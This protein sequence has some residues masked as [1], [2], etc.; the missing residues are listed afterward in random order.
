MPDCRMRIQEVPGHLLASVG[1]P[2]GHERIM[3][4]LGTC[5]NGC[6]TNGLVAV[7]VIG[8]AEARRYSIPPSP[9]DGSTT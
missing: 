1:I 9:P 5:A 3:I 7:T 4:P 8:V 2:V 6:C